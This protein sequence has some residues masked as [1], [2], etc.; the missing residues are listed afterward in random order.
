LPRG[1]WGFLVFVVLQDLTRKGREQGSEGNG[2][3]LERASGP[4]GKSGLEG[5]RGMKWCG[6]YRVLRTIQDDGKSKQR[7]EQ[8]T[9]RT[10]N[11]KDKGNGNGNREIRGLSTCATDGLTV[12][13][14]G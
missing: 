13:R 4:G 7:Q 5:G 3:T 14:A 1:Y 10:S 12:R 8:A 6:G 2:K 11:G 9:A